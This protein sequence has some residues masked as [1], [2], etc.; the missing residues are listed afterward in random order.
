MNI[1]NERLSKLKR[2][3]PAIIFISTIHLWWCFNFPAYVRLGFPLNYI[4][5]LFMSIFGVVVYAVMFTAPQKIVSCL[6]F[7]QIDETVF[8]GHIL[9]RIMPIWII[10]VYHITMLVMWYKDFYHMP[11]I[12]YAILYV[13]CVVV[14]LLLFR[15]ARRDS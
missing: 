15:A 10:F 9:K 5:S 13:Y 4:L 3:L 11:G 2:E 1:S 7:D 8:G 14:Y 12:Y 6:K